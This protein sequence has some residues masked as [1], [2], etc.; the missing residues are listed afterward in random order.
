MSEPRDALPIDGDALADAVPAPRWT[1]IGTVGSPVRSIVDPRGLV[2]PGADGWS[3]DWWI[4]AEDRWHFAGTE[5]AVRQSLIG[6]APVVETAMRVPGGDAVERVYA[7][8]GDRGRGELLIIEIENSSAAPFEVALAL[9]PYNPTGPAAIGRIAIGNGGVVTVDGR[10]SLLLARRPSAFTTCRLGDDLTALV[11]AHH[12]SDAHHS[13][14]GASGQAQ[15]AVIYPLAHRATLRFAVPLGRGTS[16]RRD[17]TRRR[18]PAQSPE[19]PTQVAPAMTVVRAWGAQTRRGMRL[20]LPPGRLAEATEV[21][22]KYLLVFHSGKKFSAGHRPAPSSFVVSVLCALGQY[23][24]HD[25][26]GEV[27]RAFAPSQGLAGRLSRDRAGSDANGMVIHAI[28]NHWRLVRE[29]ELLDELASSVWRAARAIDRRPRRPL[30]VWPVVGM[31]DAAEILDAGGQGRHAAWC[32]E[33]AAVLQSDLAR[34]L[35]RLSGVGTFDEPGVRAEVALAVSHL[36]CDPF[37]LR[38]SDNATVVAATEVAK[39]LL[40]QSDENLRVD[41]R[42]SASETLQLAA[43]DLASGNPAAIG[44]LERVLREA[45]ATYTWSTMSGPTRRGGPV[46]VGHDGQTAAEFLSLVR[47]LLVREV[48]VERARAG[49]SR[50]GLAFCSM[51][52]DSWRGQPIEIA[53]APTAV[54]P[55]SFALRWHGPRPAILWELETHPGTEPVRLTA[56]GLDPSWSSLEARGEALLVGGSPLGPVDGAGLLGVE[57]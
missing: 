52:P 26:A 9:R 57:R 2:T 46:S 50:T 51:L 43:I 24:F 27:L 36:V 40:S 54:G 37:G 35:A 30:G 56:P 48:P 4:G 3:L 28:V 49:D 8:M 6:L 47:N 55:V 39:R 32:R 12:S 1:T 44:R 10:P 20:E 21:N 11:M 42:L 34:S 5:P 53:D 22:R 23:G 33:Q 41:H 18:R 7:V 19:F 45:T 13:V 17:V 29:R 31:W 25:E 16:H 38:G 15:A 14:R